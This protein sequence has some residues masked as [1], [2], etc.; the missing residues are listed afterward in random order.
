MLSLNNERN[1]VI[2]KSAW[3]I[4]QIE[5]R[6]YQLGLL[7]SVGLPTIVNEIRKL[8]HDFSVFA[9]PEYPGSYNQIHSILLSIENQV[10][11]MKNAE[12]WKGEGFCKLCN[13]HLS[14]LSRGN[15]MIL[16]CDKCSSKIIKPLRDL[17]KPTEVWLI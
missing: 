2:Y 5:K 11:E 7:S 17:E 8:C 13:G 14:S 6:A 12:V 4:D 16:Q 15:E 9:K 1:E 10:T 3:F